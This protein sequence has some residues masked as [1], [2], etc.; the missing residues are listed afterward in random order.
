MKTETFDSPA[1]FLEAL[2]GKP[3]QKRGRATRPDIPSAP[4][5]EGKR[6]PKERPRATEHQ[7]QASFF[8]W[9]ARF[10][11]R[12]YELGWLYAIPNGGKRDE[13]VGAQMQAEGVKPGYPDIGLDVAR[14]G[15]HGLRI[16][17]KVKGGSVRTNQR[18]WHEH[19]E[20][21]G[22]KVYVCWIWEE[23]ARAVLTYLDSEYDP[24]EYGL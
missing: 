18:I 15:W 23:A 9:A 17:M 2:H 14:G 13:H 22:Y 8:D 16:E 12:I 3:R 20:R 1:A 24:K 11:G 6:K 7:E 5:G 19:L 21:C 10:S 4:A